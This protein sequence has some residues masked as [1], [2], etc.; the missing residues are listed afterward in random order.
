MNLTHL[1]YFTIIVEE[2]SISA[3]AKRLFI[4]QQAVSSAI[5]KLESD[6]GVKLFERTPGLVLTPIG[7]KVYENALLLLRQRDTLLHEVAMYKEGKSGILTIGAA[8]CRAQFVFPE[9]FEMMKKEYPN[10]V[11]RLVERP[12]SEELEKGILRGEIDFAL[13]QSLIN[14]TDI[15]GVELYREGLCLVVPKLYMQKTFGAETLR[16]QHQFERNGVRINELLGNPFFL[17]KANNRNR[18]V[19]DSY[20][21]KQGIILPE[22]LE[23][24]NIETLLSF[25]IRGQCITI[26]PELLLKKMSKEMSHE[27]RERINVFSIKDEMVTTTQILAYRKGRKLT[28][29]ERRLMEMFKYICDKTFM[30]GENTAA[31]HA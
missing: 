14:A 8:P 19:F 6:L 24:D 12:N 30:Q 5:I 10:L 22:I 18:Q 25:A 27:Q 17:P 9:V 4:S 2:M 26:F 21:K 23:S 7:G 28:R 3:A 1:Y 13:R 29:D 11:L 20:L 16:M 15:E 31:M